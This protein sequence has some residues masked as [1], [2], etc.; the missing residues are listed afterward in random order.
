V[1]VRNHV[2]SKLTYI[3]GVR[4]AELCGVQFG[5]VRWENFRL[6]APQA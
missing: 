5:G 6:P 4:A 1:A 2:M 3:S